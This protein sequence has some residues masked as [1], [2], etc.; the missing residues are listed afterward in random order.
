MNQFVAGEV[1]LGPTVALA[2][3]SSEAVVLK[4]MIYCLFLLPL[5]LEYLCL[6]LFFYAVFN[7]DDCPFY[8][9]NHLDGEERAGSST[10]I[11]FFISCDLV[12]CGSSSW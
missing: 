10:L 4:L 6:A 12:F 9:C 11:V 3:V 7:D 2:A 5:F 1:H 8:F